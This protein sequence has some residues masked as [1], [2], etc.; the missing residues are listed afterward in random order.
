MRFTAEQ[1]SLNGSILGPDVAPGSAEFDLFVTEVH[2]EMTTKAGQKCTAIRRIMV[3]E[4]HME[5]VQTA[6]K[7][8]LCATK[9]GHPALA[10]TQMGA[11]GLSRSTLGCASSGA[12]LRQGV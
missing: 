7:A 10:D 12:L 3:P 6:L 9:I 1:D 2:R 4:T 5:A 11:L 8:R